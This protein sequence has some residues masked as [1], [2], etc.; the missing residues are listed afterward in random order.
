MAKRE[1][2][3]VCEGGLVWGSLS[4]KT[5]KC[6][7]RKACT[8]VGNKG[9]KLQLFIRNGATILGPRGMKGLGR[10]VEQVGMFVVFLIHD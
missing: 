10:S 6:P 9:W 8:I 1:G 2:Q 7:N 4:V 3:P 5:V